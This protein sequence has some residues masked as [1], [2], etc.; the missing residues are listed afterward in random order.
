MMG[1]EGPLAAAVALYGDSADIHEKARE[2]AE[3]ALRLLECPQL[4]GIAVAFVNGKPTSASHTAHRQI[5]EE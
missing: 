3:A 4:T 1:E 2:A 5:E